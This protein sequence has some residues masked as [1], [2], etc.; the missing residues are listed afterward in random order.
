MAM[1]AATRRRSPAVGTEDEHPAKRM[2]PLERSYPIVSLNPADCDLDFNVHG[3]G[4]W[5]S[6]LHEEGFA[7]CWSGARATVGIT[8]GK[9]CFGC[10]ILSQQDVRM[11]DTPSDQQ[12]LCRIGVSS[13]ED[14]VGS[15]GETVGSGGFGGTGK[16][17]TAG[18]FTDY[19]GKFS[20]GDTVVC[21]VDLE[22]SASA[23]VGFYLNGLWLGEAWRFDARELLL[24]RSALFPH[25]LLK[26]VVVEMQ[27]CEG[28]GLIIEGGGFKPWSSALGDGNAVVGPSFAVVRNCEVVMMVGLPGS[29]KSTWAEKWKADHPEKRYILLGTNLALD[30]MKVPGL[31][32]KRNYGERFEKLMEM[33][34]GIFNTLLS[35]AARTPRNYIIDQTNVYKSARKRKLRPF[36]DFRKVAVVIFPTFAELKSRSDRRAREMGKEVPAE[37]V[38]EMIA[39]FVLPVSRDMPHADEPFDQ[40]IFTELDRRESAR[41]LEEMKRAVGSSVTCSE[42]SRLSSGPATPPVPGAHLSHLHP[43]TPFQMRGPTVCMGNQFSSPEFIPRALIDHASPPGQRYVDSFRGWEAISSVEFLASRWLGRQRPQLG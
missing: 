43:H 8:G 38:N 27:F 14:E 12:H 37:A 4:L 18:R 34:T 30:Q 39:N 6:S 35:R 1:A 7:Y 42:R 25:V 3:D 9:Y 23:T 13:R 17:S 2:R 29:G 41:S 28:D 21:A 31:L 19:G 40:I 36:A 16:F 32:R 15:L 20:I 33:A 10:R 5:G 24:R 26:N 11:E 22:N